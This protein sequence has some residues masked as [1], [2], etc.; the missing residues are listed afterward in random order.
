MTLEVPAPR[1]RGR[2]AAGLDRG[3]ALAV[4]GIAGAQSDPDQ[5]SRPSRPSVSCAD[6]KPVLSAMLLAEACN[7]LVI[8]DQRT[9]KLDRRSNQKSIRRVA[10]LEMMQLI[11]AG[12]GPVA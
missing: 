4:A 2:S 12:S 9:G 3:E 8:S 10:V 7:A 1:A 5:A 11:A 6:C